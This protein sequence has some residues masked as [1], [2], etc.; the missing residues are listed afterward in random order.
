MATGEPERPKVTERTACASLTRRSGRPPLS[1]STVAAQ[2][3]K[4][5]QVSP[6]TPPPMGR[7]RRHTSQQLL[8]RCQC[9]ESE[10]TEDVG[11]AQRKRLNRHLA[12]ETG[13][14]P[15]QVQGRGVAEVESAATAT[16]PM[17]RYSHA[18][19]YLEKASKERIYVPDVYSWREGN[20][21]RKRIC[22][23]CPK[24]RCDKRDGGNGSPVRATK[25]SQG[26]CV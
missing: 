20:L 22:Y 12:L 2:E 18:K 7:L 6:T 8:R 13:R 25:S 23:G 11:R 3:T 26:A 21:Y 9:L 5:V 19:D 1:I 17:F 16:A 4:L 15:G 24:S 10:K 14:T